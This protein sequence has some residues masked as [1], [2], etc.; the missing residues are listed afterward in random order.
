[1]EDVT[2][3]ALITQTWEMKMDGFMTRINVPRPP[4]QSVSSVSYQDES[5]SPQTLDSSNY[6]VDSNTEPGRLVESATGNYPST[7]DDINAVTITFIAGYGDNPSDVPEHF[8]QMIKLRIEQLFDMTFGPY[9][10]ALDNA[11]LSM[12]AQYKI[13]NIAL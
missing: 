11:L 8:K 7:Y 9:G 1:V 12:V 3:R 4:L 13:E 6:T 2:G 10:E 5:N